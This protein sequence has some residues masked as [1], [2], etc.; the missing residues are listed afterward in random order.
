MGRSALQVP[1]AIAARIAP[2][3]ARVIA[4]GWIRGWPRSACQ[5]MSATSA[6]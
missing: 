2:A 6:A 1:Y 4:S 3:V 5:V